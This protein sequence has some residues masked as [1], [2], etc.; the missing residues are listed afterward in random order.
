M[1]HDTCAIIE[2]CRLNAWRAIVDQCPGRVIVTET[3]V[4]EFVLKLREEGFDDL[5]NAHELLLDPI[6]SGKI[7]S[8]SLPASA[9]AIVKETSGKQF[10]GLWD[11]G[12]LESMTYLL[13]APEERVICSTERLVFR[14]LGYTNQRDR[15][16]SLEGIFAKLGLK[17]KKLAWKVT[18]EFKDHYATK[19]FEG[20]LKDGMF[21]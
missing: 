17:R 14:Y 20:A 6:H 5:G 8:P 13:K 16:I 11:A 9:L 7:I 18:Q 12:E 1:I 19:G 4:G 2:A 15:G 21:R 3:V 10:V